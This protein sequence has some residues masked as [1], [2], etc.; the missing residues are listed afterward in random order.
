MINHNKI[1]W[2]EGMA[3]QPVHFQQQ[4]KYH[5]YRTDAKIDLLSNNL[6]GFTEL[7]LD[8][9][10]LSIGKLG[11]AS[12]K[13]VFPDG[14]VFNMPQ[15][16]RVPDAFPVI[17]GLLN[18]TL[19]LAL[20]IKQT[21]TADSGNS[22]SK[23]SYR[24]HAVSKNLI[25]SVADSL[26]EAEV[27]VGSIACKL[28]TNQENLD[29]YTCLPI[30]RITES[31]SNNVIILDKT[32]IAPWLDAHKADPLEKFL[33]E[34]KV[35]LNNRAEMLAGRLTDTQQAGTADM[36]DLMLLQLSNRYQAV[37]DY[38]GTK[39]PLH[40]EQFYFHLAEMMMEV[41]TYTTNSRR[42]NKVLAYDHQQLYETFK[43]LIKDVRHALSMVL[44]QNA[45]AIHLENR[46]HGLWVGQIN[47]KSLLT[48]CNFVLAV[49]AAQPMEAIR[50]TF[51]S[52]IKIAPVEQI[53]TLVSK[54]LPGITLQ[55]IAVAPR[56]IP[57]HTNF[58][59]FSLDNRGDLWQALS[60]SG[61]IALHISGSI[62]ELKL[63]LW[64]I[65]G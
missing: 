53:K 19:Y 62:P 5:E 49:Y 46:G 38:L 55:S 14:T 37:F 25:D 42:P 13:G 48:S 65:K 7:E 26:S 64:A 29:N 57:H 12:A 58:C 33:E 59:Y 52:Q 50:L 40:P 44:E 36:V 2:H 39:R 47:D 18:A 35:L 16:D 8:T 23:Q 9:N 15:D 63:Q 11:I 45:A 6:W 21:S 17:E 4:E 1:I 31:K 22:A 51:P 32:F 20:P 56:Q 61:G 3:L 27:T 10:A 43:P 28:V 30:A 34:V 54:A 24:Y 41:A 60:Q